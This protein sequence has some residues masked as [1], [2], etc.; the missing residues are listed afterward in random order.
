MHMTSPSEP[1]L[2]RLGANVRERRAQLALTLRE[3]ALLSGVSQRFLVSLEAGKANVSVLKL[4]AV[5]TALDTTAAGLLAFGAAA[6]ARVKQSRGRPLALLGLRGAGKSAIGAR[7]ARRLGWPFVELDGHI[8]EL[9]GM[10]LEG[11]FALHGAD[12]YR[13]L[14]RQ[15]LAA[16]L[17]RPR[18]C[19]LATGGGIVTNHPAYGMLKGKC[20]TVF[21]QATAEH[22]WERVVAQGDARPMADRSDAMNELRGILRARRALYERADKTLDTSTLGLERSVD[23]VVRIA[24]ELAR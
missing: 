6:P 21:L 18:A 9:A 16:M 23:A 10:T 8:S 15:A 19:V 5:A 1:L 20:V 13:R 17:A 7:A 3:V 2:C 24:R 22:H 4:A 11:V 14:E 12:Y